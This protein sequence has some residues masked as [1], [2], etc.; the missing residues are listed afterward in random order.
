MP[1][2]V[3]PLALFVKYVSQQKTKIKFIMKRVIVFIA[4]ISIGI[5]A[6][7]QIA[8]N[9]LGGRFY[10]GGDF[11]GAELS[12]QKSV[13]DRNRTEVDASFGFRHDNTRVALV[14]MYHWVWSLPGRF[15][16]FAGPG[17]TVS[18]DSYNDN[19]YLNIGLG[20]QI[21]IEYN[22]RGIPLMVSLDA[23]PIWDFLGDVNGLGWGTAIGIR[24]TW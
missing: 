8:P 17:A 23:R 24:Y 6:T 18:Y 22:F 20:G 5:L 10:G 19:N 12:Y 15:S 2:P 3:N 9:A 14:G 11:N 21:G 16:W 13:S 7:A 4:A 1:A